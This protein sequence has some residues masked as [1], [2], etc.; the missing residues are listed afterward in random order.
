MSNPFDFFD[1]IYCINL[2][3]S[4]DRKNK[5]TEEF[6]KIGILNRVE[7]ICAKPPPKNFRISNFRYVGELG[8][9]LSQIKCMIRSMS[10]NSDNC[11]IFEDDVF[12][13]D[14]ILQRMK[15]GINQL[16]QNWNAL[17]LGGNPKEKLKDYSSELSSVGLILGAYGYSVNKPFMVELV[18]KYLDKFTSNFPNCTVDDIIS[19]SVR[20]NNS[21]TFDLPVCHPHTGLSIIR[22]AHRDYHNYINNL[23]KKYS[24]KK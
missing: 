16:P 21:Y 15:N 11:L 19:K 24:A 8:V 2:P 9:G 5:M 14:N 17:Y 1:D 10:R 7:W 23:W 6:N 12:F 18:E 22:N 20:N 3:D 4:V 13:D